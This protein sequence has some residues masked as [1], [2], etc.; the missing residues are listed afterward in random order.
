[1]SLFFRITCSDLTQ[2]ERGSFQAH[3][4]HIS[5]R[6]TPKESASFSHIKYGK[7]CTETALAQYPASHLNIPASLQLD[8]EE[9]QGLNQGFPFCA[10]TGDAGCA[11]HQQCHSPLCSL[12]KRHWKSPV[13][14]K[15]EAHRYPAFCITVTSGEIFP[16]WISQCRNHPKQPPTHKSW[17]RLGFKH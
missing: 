15:S 1:M 17:S 6:D 11:S 5:Y 4:K 2:A 10:A 14:W 16:K 12:C 7:P 3:R 8:P 9:I 13:N